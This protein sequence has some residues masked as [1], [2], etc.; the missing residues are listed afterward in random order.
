M[1][2]QEKIAFMGTITKKKERS[3]CPSNLF[4]L[5]RPYERKKKDFPDSSS[6]ERKENQK[7]KEKT[8][9]SVL[10]DISTRLFVSFYFL[11]LFY[12]DEDGK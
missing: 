9:V 5:I 10:K 1:D 6:E 12:S 4:S 8:I 2:G 3:S 7:R 11:F